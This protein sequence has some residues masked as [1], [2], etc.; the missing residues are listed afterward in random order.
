VSS[1]KRRSDEDRTPSQPIRTKSPTALNLLDL[2][3]AATRVA[4]QWDQAERDD[5]QVTMHGVGLTLFQL[6][7]DFSSVGLTIIGMRKRRGGGA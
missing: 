3:T 7:R 6:G 1:S 5:D 4:R 2:A